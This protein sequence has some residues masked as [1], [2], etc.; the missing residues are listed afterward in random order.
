MLLKLWPE[1]GITIVDYSVQIEQ[2]KIA[3]QVIP[4]WVFLPRCTEVGFGGSNLIQ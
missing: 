2:A 1:L 3:L 4:N